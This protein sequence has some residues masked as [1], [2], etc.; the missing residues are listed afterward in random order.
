MVDALFGVVTFIKSDAASLFGLR[1][2][3]ESKRM[4]AFFDAHQVMDVVGL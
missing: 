4:I 2:L 1:D 3:L